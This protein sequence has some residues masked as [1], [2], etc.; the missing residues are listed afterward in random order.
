LAW[1]NAR[2]PPKLLYHS[3]SSAGQ[4]RGNMMTGSCVETR[5]GRDHSPI[6]VRD[7]TDNLER[8]GKFNLS[9]I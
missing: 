4:G 9:P 8:K 1:I 6:T 5:T 3:H 2:C 7:K